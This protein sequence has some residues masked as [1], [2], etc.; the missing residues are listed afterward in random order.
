MMRSTVTHLGRT[1]LPKRVREAL[2]LRPG[3]RLIYELVAG[4]VLVRPEGGSPRID[5]GCAHTEGLSAGTPVER[6]EVEDTERA[7]AAAAAE[8]LKTEFHD[9][10]RGLSVDD[11]SDWTHEGHRF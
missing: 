2:G 10:F 6:V 9:V 4:G 8:R 11:L 3:Q 1:T 7:R 5:Q